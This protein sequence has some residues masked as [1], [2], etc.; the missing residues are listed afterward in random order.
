MSEPTTKFKRAPRDAAHRAST[1]RARRDARR[2]RVGSRSRD[3]ASTARVARRSS[4]RV[5][6]S[7]SSSL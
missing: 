7:S 1:T 2:R 6:A 4:R 3:I 5:V